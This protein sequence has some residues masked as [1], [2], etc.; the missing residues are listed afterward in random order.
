MAYLVAEVNL[1]RAWLA[2]MELMRQDGEAVNL[3]VAWQGGGTEEP[4]VRRQ[5]DQFLNG[6]PDVFGVETVADTIFP[7]AFYHPHLG[8][9]EA[10][11]R[12][13]EL[14][15]DAMRL[16]RRRKDP[17]DRETYFNRLVNYPSADGPFNQL[18]FIVSRLKTKVGQA[19]AVSSA[20][21]L[22]L[23]TT[24]EMRVQAP[25]ADRNYMRFPCL[26][27]ISITLSGHHHKVINLTA[28]YRNQ[29]FISRAYGNYLGLSRLAEAIAHQTDGELGEIQCIATHASAEYGDFN[30]RPVKNLIAACR[31]ALD[32]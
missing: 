29:T 9:E 13:F 1:S 32:A 30:K 18:E 8:K 19:R 25:G 5:L 14:N 31:E 27:H 10:L 2:A 4:A 20:Y 22:G 24:A 12:L 28:T 6:Y 3:N 17:N 16:H 23:S 15:N 26:S 7:E 21:E 11:S